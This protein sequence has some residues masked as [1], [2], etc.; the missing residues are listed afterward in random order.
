MQYLV[1]WGALHVTMLLSVELLK[2][3]RVRLQRHN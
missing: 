3:K 2:T 1:K